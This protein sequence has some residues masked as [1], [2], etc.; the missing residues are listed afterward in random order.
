MKVNKLS[1]VIPI[2]EWLA[3]YRAEWLRFDV[4]AGLTAAAV[5]IP[6]AL[7]YASIA[8]LPLQVGLYMV[9]VPV[10]IYAVLGSSRTL[11]MSTTTTLGILTAAELSTVA[12]S[13]NPAELLTATCTLA[14]LVGVILLLAS[15]FRLG[16]VANFISEPVLTGFKAGIGLVIILDQA[17]K[18]F[19]VHFDKGRFVHNLIAFVGTCQKHRFTRCCSAGL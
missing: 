3:G 11:S 16:F 7:A 17:P 8:G 15:L 19:G 5:V 14:L 2:S 13:G 10:V 4:I 18:L 9:F 6:K 1:S 12:T